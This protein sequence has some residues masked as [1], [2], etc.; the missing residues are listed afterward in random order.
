VDHAADRELAIVRLGFG[1]TAV[2][3]PQALQLQRDLHARRVAGEIPDT[4]LLLEHPAVFTAG[5]RTNP[6][7]RPVGDAGAPVIEVRSSACRSQ[8]TWS[9]T[10]AP[11]K[12]S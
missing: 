11:R 7:D 12:R 9:P 5:K 1:A 8:S 2:P 3:Y 4:V 6:E 10:C